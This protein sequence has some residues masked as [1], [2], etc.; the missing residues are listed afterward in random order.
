[1]GRKD[2]PEN[3]GD[4]GLGNFGDVSEVWEG[5]RRHTQQTIR[6]FPPRLM[7]VIEFAAA[8]VT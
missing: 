1:V 7:N 6:S 3:V 2:C 8:S 4:P 5:K